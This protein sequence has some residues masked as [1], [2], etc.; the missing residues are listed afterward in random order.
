[1]SRVDL[2]LNAF[3]PEKAGERE[4]TK[5]KKTELEGDTIE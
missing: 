4:T 5:K 3:A 2:K 1:M